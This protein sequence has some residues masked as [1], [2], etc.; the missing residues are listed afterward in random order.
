MKP[1]TICIDVVIAIVLVILY[2]VRNQLPEFF[3]DES[4]QSPGKK[5]FSLSR[6]LFCFWTLLI[7]FSFCYIGITKD[8]LPKIDSN[9]LL[10]MG[11][12]SGT[13]LAGRAIDKTQAA[14][15]KVTRIQDQARQNFLKDILTDANGISISRFQTLCFN[16]IY[17]GIFISTLFVSG[18]IFGFDASALALLG[19][20][21]GA[22]AVT[23]IPEN[24]P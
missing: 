21:S 15:P 8:E 4:T 14:N 23:K 18:Q 16:L 13:A 11:I 22:Y 24:Q 7:F 17:G 6:T 9:I 1:L 3:E 19:L 2:L 12:A 5:P 10:L 20:S